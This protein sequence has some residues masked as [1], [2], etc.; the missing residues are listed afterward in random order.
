MRVR[1]AADAKIQAINV[2][3]AA[4]GKCSN[5]KEVIVCE[6]TGEG[7]WAAPLIVQ[8]FLINR[9]AITRRMKRSGFLAM[10]SSGAAKPPA[11]EA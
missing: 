9:Y 11:E 3:R 8:F 7:A 6:I 10:T 4:S 2:Q 5:G 1:R